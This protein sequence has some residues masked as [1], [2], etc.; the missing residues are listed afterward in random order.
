MGSETGG[1]QDAQFQE[2]AGCTVQT[3]AE[4]H[5]GSETGGGGCGSEMGDSSLTH[6]GNS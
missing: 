4:G 1:R 5:L 2:F 3:A 6:S